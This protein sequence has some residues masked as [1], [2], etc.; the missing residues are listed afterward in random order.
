MNTEVV[1]KKFH[2]TLILSRVFYSPIGFS[3]DSSENPFTG[4]HKLGMYILQKIATDSWKQLQKKIIQIKKNSE[5][6]FCFKKPKKV[7][8]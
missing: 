8:T 5:G 4:C 3:P 7:C 1:H 2:L 6:I